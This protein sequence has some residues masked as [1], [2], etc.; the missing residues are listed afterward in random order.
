[1][2]KVAIV[3]LNYN[4]KNHLEKFLPSVVMNSPEAGIYIADNASTDDSVSFIEENYPTL[5]LIRIPV[6][7]G[8]SKGYNIALQSV[9]SRYYI[10]LNSDVEVNQGWLEPLIR[11]MDS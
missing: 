10:L 11:L 3:I 7:Y 9:K 5:H 2:D 6:N 4:G 8:Y 1:M